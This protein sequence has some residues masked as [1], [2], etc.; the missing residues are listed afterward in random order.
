M[1]IEGYEHLVIKSS[2][3]FLSGTKN[4]KIACCTYHRSSDFDEISTMLKDN[5]FSIEASDGYMIF[6]LGDELKP[7]YFRKGILRAKN[8]Q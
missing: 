2:V 5:G 6:P 3:K 1:D 8:N 4:V 7:P